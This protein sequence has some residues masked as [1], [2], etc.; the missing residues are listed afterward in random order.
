MIFWINFYFQVIW[1]IR[2]KVMALNKSGLLAPTHGLIPDTYSS[3]KSL[4]KVMVDFVFEESSSRPMCAA[5]CLWM[6]LV[7][8][9][10]SG[11]S[12]VVGSR[13][14]YKLV[15]DPKCIN[16]DPTTPFT[17]LPEPQ[18]GSDPPVVTVSYIEFF[19]VHRCRNWFPVQLAGA[20]CWVVWEDLYPHSL[21]QTAI[22]LN[23][24]PVL[25]MLPVP[26]EWN[27]NLKCPQSMVSV[28]LLPYYDV[29]AQPR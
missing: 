17:N 21:D 7:L 26:V 19:C 9:M 13:W 4:T 5:L 15:T 2:L 28:A 29:R 1:I 12:A 23:L 8:N 3:L 20:V 16:S 27:L 14:Q 11:I 6:S 10:L 24:E 22:L 18:R 25:F